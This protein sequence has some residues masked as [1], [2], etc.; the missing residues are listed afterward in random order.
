MK[1]ATYRPTFPPILYINFLIKDQ[2][3]KDMEN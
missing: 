2:W 3:S 1:Y